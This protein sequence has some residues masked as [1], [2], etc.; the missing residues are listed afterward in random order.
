MRCKHCLIGL[1]WEPIIRPTS[2]WN[3]YTSHT[4]QAKL[5]QQWTQTLCAM[6]HQLEMKL[7]IPV[8]I[9]NCCSSREKETLAKV[10]AVTLHFDLL[11][12]RR[13]SS[14]HI[15]I[16]FSLHMKSLLEGANEPVKPPLFHLQVFI[17]GLQAGNK[18][19]LYRRHTQDLR[20]LFFLRITHKIP[21]EW[22]Y[23]FP[24]EKAYNSKRSDNVTVN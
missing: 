6:C 15:L 4:Q 18:Q 22:V 21:S 23:V 16:L 3:H 13:A 17:S 5:L 12:A 20:W 9:F 8:G 7:M 1:S 14:R 10:K 11:R 24:G 19:T 2:H